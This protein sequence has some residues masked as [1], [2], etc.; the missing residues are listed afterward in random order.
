MDIDRDA[1]ESSIKEALGVTTRL[2]LQTFKVLSGSLAET[3]KKIGEQDAAVNN[4]YRDLNTANTATNKS[5]EVKNAA[6]DKTVTLA[7]N[8]KGGDYVSQRDTIRNIQGLDDQTKNTLENYY[9]AFYSTEKLQQ[10]DSALGA[11]PPHGEFDSSYYKTQSPAAAQQWDSAVAND[12]IDITQRYGEGG[13][14]SSTIQPKAS[15][16]VFAGIKQR[17]PQRQMNT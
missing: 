5:N 8:T 3:K 4:S 17:L 14:I 1:T 13:F 12:D 2:G 9:K 15:L 6:Y 10:W 16:P 7:N 11:K